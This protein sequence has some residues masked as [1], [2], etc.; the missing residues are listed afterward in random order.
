MKSVLVSRFLRFALPAVLAIAF[1]GSHANAQN[2]SVAVVDKASSPIMHFY[3]TPSGQDS[4]G[5][6]LLGEDIVAVNHYQVIDVDDG[7]NTC[8]YDFKAVLQDGS[9][10]TQYHVNACILEV[11]TVY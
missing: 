8:I 6:D 2:K 9:V 1:M 7:S 3:A 4:W 10:A 5:Y 11:W